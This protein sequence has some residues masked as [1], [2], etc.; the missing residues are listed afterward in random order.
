MTDFKLIDK[1]T[2]IKSLN[3]NKYDWDVVINGRQYYVMRIEGYVHTIGGKYGENDLWAYPRNEEPSY[4]NLIEFGCENPVCWGI[5]YEPYNYTKCKW[6]ECEAK[7]ANGIV[8]TRNGE[9][10]CDE[11]FGG[12]DK[13]KVMISEFNEHPLGF[14]EID[15][16]N[17]AIGRKV[18]WRSEPAVI[19][20]YINGQACVILKPDGIKGFTVPAEFRDEDPEYYCEGDVKTSVLDKH[21]WWFRE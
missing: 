5:R 2:D 11:V 8:I 9:D 6:G 4:E 3:M 1:N 7:S 12:L 21:I 20:N 16:D 19:T 14:N 18:W 13:A 10:F 17:K 15:F